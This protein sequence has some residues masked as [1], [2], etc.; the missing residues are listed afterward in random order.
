MKKQQKGGT[1]AAIFGLPNKYKLVMQ[2]GLTEYLEREN[3]VVDAELVIF[4]LNV[5][6]R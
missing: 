5:H 6:M 2:I 3:T 4:Q 1:R